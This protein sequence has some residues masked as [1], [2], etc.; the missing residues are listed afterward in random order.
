M[1]TYGLENYGI[2]GIKEV[3]YNPSYEALFEAE[4]DPAL[5]GF[6]KGQIDRKSVV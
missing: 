4:M 2:T 5:E 6:E 1:E 3:V